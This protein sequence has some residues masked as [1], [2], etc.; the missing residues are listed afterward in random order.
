[1]LCKHIILKFYDVLNFSSTL[2]N[3]HFKAFYKLE[4]KKQ[5]ILE[6]MLIHNQPEILQRVLQDNFYEFDINFI[7][8]Y[9]GKKLNDKEK[10]E[11]IN[12]EDFR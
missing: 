5:M 11:P 3:E 4:I 12:E 7:F 6:H 2:L 9:I 10:G 1:M 8:D